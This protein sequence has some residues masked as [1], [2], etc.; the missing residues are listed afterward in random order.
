M[1]IEL[2]EVFLYLVSF[3]KEA[4][5]APDCLNAWVTH[6]PLARAGM[7]LVLCFAPSAVVQYRAASRQKA[8]RQKAV[9][10]CAGRDRMS[11]TTRIVQAADLTKLAVSAGTAGGLLY[12]HNAE[13]IAFVFGALVNA[14]LTKLLKAIIN[15]PRPDAS[16]QEKKERSSGMPSSHSSSL[17]YFSVSLVLLSPGWHSPIILGLAILGASWRVGAKYHTVAQVIVGL[18]VG[19][20]NGYAWTTGATPYVVDAINRVIG[21][22]GPW[23]VTAALAALVRIRPCHARANIRHRPLP[24]VDPGRSHRPVLPTGF[25]STALNP[26]NT[27]DLKSTVASRFLSHVSLNEGSFGSVH[28]RAEKTCETQV[29]A[30]HC[31][32]R[33]RPELC[34]Y[35]HSAFATTYP[36]SVSARVGSF[37]KLCGFA[38]PAKVT[39]GNERGMEGPADE[40]PRTRSW[41]F[42]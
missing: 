12:F 22:W 18:L 31:Q 28:N 7:S 10:M 19:G 34:H 30:T 21:F 35:A 23:P 9:C 32:N 36:H 24:R 2:R 15:A 42:A 13:A 14:L 3:D 1:Q 8:S 25:E 33:A 5:R 39:R 38:I 17:A 40:T 41:H 37:S 29:D 11:T 16:P 20:A 27:D 4:I 6:P 26:T